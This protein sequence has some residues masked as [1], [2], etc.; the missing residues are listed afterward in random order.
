[1]Y[2]RDHLNVGLE[3]QTSFLMV[4]D[5]CNC[6]YDGSDDRPAVAG[7]AATTTAT[8]AAAMASATTATSLDSSAD[9]SEFCQ[10]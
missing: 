9:G 1:M 3:L 7:D 5:Q 10:R 6:C 4:A 2:R 8:D